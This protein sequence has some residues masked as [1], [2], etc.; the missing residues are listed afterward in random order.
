[1]EECVE[2]VGNGG[3]GLR[4]LGDPRS[5]PLGAS[6][7]LFWND[8]LAGGI[9]AVLGGYSAYEAR[10]TDASNGD[11]DDDGSDSGD[12]SGSDG[13]NGDSNDESNGGN[14]SDSDSSDDGDGDGDG[15][16]NEDDE[17]DSSSGG[18]AV[19]KDCGEGAGSS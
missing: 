13:S 12:G 2:P 4:R 10:E 9:V 11:S 6:T 17:A 15:D 18:Q 5:L 14:G 19:R 3:G 8:L 1:V 7:I 16:G